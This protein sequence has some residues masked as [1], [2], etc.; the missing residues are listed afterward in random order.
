MLLTYVQVLKWI[1]SC[2][3]LTGISILIL[4][5]IYTFTLIGVHTWCT[6]IYFWSLHIIVPVYYPLVSHQHCLKYVVYGSFQLSHSCVSPYMLV[7]GMF[8][9]LLY[10]YIVN[11]HMLVV[12]LSFSCSLAPMKSAMS[13]S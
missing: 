9:C 1:W 12:C 6:F 2:Q 5:R 3:V 13:T 4:N 10:E 8:A 11:V 7:T